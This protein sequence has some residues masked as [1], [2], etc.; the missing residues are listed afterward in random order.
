MRWEYVFN[1]NLKHWGLSDFLKAVE[2]S[3]YEYFT[4]NGRVYRRS[5]ESTMIET[6]IYVKDLR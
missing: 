6:D 4:W 1:D 2:Y 3:G 5:E